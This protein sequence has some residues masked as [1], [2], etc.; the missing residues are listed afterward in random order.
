MIR[1]IECLECWRSLEMMPT[2]T[3]D[4]AAGWKRRVV[5][6]R[7]KKP[8]DHQITIHS[9]DETETVNLASVMCDLCGAPIPDGAEAKA[10]TMWNENRE[11]EPGN[12]EMDYE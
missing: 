12:W 2:P 11:G 8:A 4:V 9:G 10:V 5:T 7:A 3:E 1:K 6:I